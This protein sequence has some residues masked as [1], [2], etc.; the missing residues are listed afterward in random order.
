M[1]VVLATS[2][3]NSEFDVGTFRF[4]IHC[5]IVFTEG[6]FEGE[7]LVVHPNRPRG[8]LEI[9]LRPTKNTPVDIHVKVAVGPAGADLMQVGKEV[10]WCEEEP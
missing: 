7:T 1:S 2:D 3:K 4:Q 8:E 10:S 6:V 5:A 9:E